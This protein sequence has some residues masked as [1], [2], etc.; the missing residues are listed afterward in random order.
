MFF[1]TLNT[2]FEVIHLFNKLKRKFMEDGYLGQIILFAGNFAP[3]NWMLC[4]GQSL[5]VAQYQALYS[6]L[7]NLYGGTAGTSFNLPDLR[8]IVPVSAGV[9][10]ASGNIYSL[11]VRGG[12]EVTSLSVNQLPSHNHPLVGQNTLSVSGNITA[13]M[14]VNNTAQNG[15]NPSGQYLG[16]DGGGS[17]LYANSTDNTTLNTNAINVNSSGLTVNASGLQV[18]NSGLGQPFSNMQPYLGLNY[19]ICV[20]G[21]Y[22]TKP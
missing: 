11:G 10:P 18:G 7:G 13:T 5:S 20:S 4:N 22:P 3:V 16:I 2:M 6:V 15:S 21:L 1:K 9:S 17:G 14:K 12:N 8:G 19:I